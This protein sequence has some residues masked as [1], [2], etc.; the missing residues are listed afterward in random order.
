MTPDDWCETPISAEH[1]RKGFD[2]GEPELNTYLQRYAR[3]NHKN[4]TAKCFVLTPRHAPAQ[5]LGFYTLS[6]A[7]VAYERTPETI[8]KGL[9]RYGVPVFRLGRLAVDCS[10]Q[11]R[12]WAASC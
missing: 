12:R 8:R 3:Q 10:V 5:V 4:G 1:D 9:G 6:A 2:C 7:E 11:G